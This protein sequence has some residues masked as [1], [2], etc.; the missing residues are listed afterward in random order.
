LKL[1]VKEPRLTSPTDTQ[2]SPTVQ[3]VIR[4]REA[5]RSSRLVSRYWCGDSP[6]VRRNSRLKWALERPA[7]PAISATSTGSE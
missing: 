6:N 3:S 5:A 7:A 4:S 1:V 2:I